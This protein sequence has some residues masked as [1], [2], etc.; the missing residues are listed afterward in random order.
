MG[1]YKRK[2]LKTLKAICNKFENKRARHILKTISCKAMMSHDIK[3]NESS[4]KSRYRPEID[5]LRAFAVISVI[6]NHFNKDILPGGYLGV[7]IF[8]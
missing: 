4:T 6:V 8:F 7:D 1:I 3:E 2:I 5:G